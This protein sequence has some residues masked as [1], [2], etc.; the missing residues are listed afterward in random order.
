[1]GEKSANNLLNAIEKSKSNDLSK[2]IFA[3]GISR[4]ATAGHDKN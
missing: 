2:L 1:M 4:Y 3:L